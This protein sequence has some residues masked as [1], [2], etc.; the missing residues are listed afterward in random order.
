MWLLGRCGRSLAFWPSFYCFF[1][2]R[3]CWLVLM[4]ACTRYREVHLDVWILP[5]CL[6]HTQLVWLLYKKDANMQEF[7]G[8]LVGES[9]KQWKGQACNLSAC[10]Q[11]FVM[12]GVCSLE[13][14]QLLCQAASSWAHY[15]MS[16][17]KQALLKE[18][19]S[20]KVWAG[21]KRKFQK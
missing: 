10:N 18:R 5:K 14:R 4:L 9:L 1:S 3:L 7:E 13:N 20:Q 16:S 11:L 8:I 21:H 2:W 17:S 6:I 15:V 12:C 19:Q